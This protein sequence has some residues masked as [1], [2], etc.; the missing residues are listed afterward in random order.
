ML[1]GRDR[2]RAT[3]EALIAEAHAGRSAVLA[4]VGEAGIGKSTLLDWAAGHAEGLEVVRARGIQSEAQIPFAGLFELLR[5][6]LHLLDRIPAPQA[7]AL[8]SAL[9]LRPGKG[10]NRFAVGAATLSLLAA[11]AE[12]TPLLLLVDDAHWLD[13]SSADAL[14]FA[15]R[16]L[17]A[18]PIAVVLS[19]RDG[20]P[21]LLDGADLPL[22]CLEA[23]A[24]EPAAELLRHELPG[25]GA[26]TLERLLREAG[27]NPLAL[28]ELAREGKPELGLD[29]P[30]PV[31]TSVAAAYLNR[32]R[33]LPEPTR[34][35]LVLAAATDRGE[36]ALHARAAAALGLASADLGPA[37]QARLIETR[38]G[39]LEFCHPLARSA[40]YGDADVEE[41][42]AVHRALAGA[43]PDSDAD[44]RA[45][46]LALAA[47]GPDE[48]ASA[49]LAQ[50]AGRARGRSAYEV[51]SSAYERSARLA[52][53]DVRR[54]SMLYA[55]ADTA[56]LG[57]QAERA[58]GLLDEVEA[59]VPPHRAAR[60]RGEIALR[61][62]PLHEA[63]V[64]LVAAA[65][66]AAAEAPE[67][68]VAMLAE[69][70][71]G[72]FYET[73]TIALR[74]CGERAAAIAG[75]S[76]DWRTRFL[77][78]ITEGMALVLR[79]EGERG[80]AA[81]REGIDEVEGAHAAD[82][83]ARLLAWATLGPL[84][85]RE[86]G[87][88]SE[89][90]ARA[91]EAARAES[92]V[93][94]LPHLLLYVATGHAASESWAEAQAGFDEAI[95]LARETGL[96]VVLAGALARLGRLE[97]RMGH[98]QDARRHTD[99]ALALAREVEAVL[100]EVWA[101]TG[102][103]ELELVVGDV[104]AALAALAELQETI[105]R[106]HVE[107]VDLLPAP[108]QV[109]LLLR[110]GRPAEAL[111][112]VEPYAAA[113]AEKGQPWA[114]ARAARA[115][116]LVA[117]DDAFA[118]HFDVALELHDRTPDVFE[119]A[120][121]LLVYGGRL[122]RAGRRSDA[123]ER[124][125]AAL[126]IFEELGAVP[127]ADLARAE[128]AATGETARRREAATL[129]ELTPQELQI[130]LLLADGK[131]TREAASA[132]FLSPKTIEYHLRNAYRKLAVHS[133]DELREALRARPG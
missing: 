96:R 101:L 120:R 111:A 83:D 40:I 92:A 124:L 17:L 76:S 109:E 89:L 106:R 4:L 133:R 38:D 103:A 87:T 20:A 57:G 3:L 25:A 18:D 14:L 61:R 107:D 71:L 9:A 84:F 77:A 125:R 115:R 72:A 58:L 50:A 12:A 51:A 34:R 59:G 37:E 29:A 91:A 117:G 105:A 94:L 55:A 22:L 54:G 81:I 1:L 67:D 131:T 24:P 60:L 116:G 79:G 119:R 82:A 112:L 5:P 100:C 21:S 104:G 95:R 13:G 102:L 53:D 23:L 113:A 43:L 62:G 39:K 108:E 19:V 49:A 98:E 68:A 65:E 64:R 35:V 99:E 11:K 44:R 27:G 56:W 48:N 88:G 47:A 78:R 127:W 42:R 8:E 69:A 80:A 63:R 123:R 26:E 114:L 73:D 74:R 30:P 130:S 41:R 10:E 70:S 15:V 52:T 46:H 16:R 31:V 45:W 2:E 97:G 118:A 110:A 128:L 129:D 28:R 75:Q 90:A 85:L 33:A 66:E 93:G 6:A 132:L 122:R 36:P 121:T 126:A 32:A 86:A 7:A